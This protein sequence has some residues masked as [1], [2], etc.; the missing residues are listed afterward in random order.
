MAGREAG[1]YLS[2][3]EFDAVCPRVTSSQMA[4]YVALATTRNRKTMRTPPVGAGLLMEKT[5][6]SRP[7]VFADVRGLCEAGFLTKEKGRG[8]NVY[9]FPMAVPVAARK[10][11]I[12]DS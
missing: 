6:K 3:R 8:G 9:G 11:G 5:G 2:Q 4:V 10:P 7:R 1:C 12:P